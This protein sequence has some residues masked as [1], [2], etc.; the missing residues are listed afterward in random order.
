L[1][2]TGS[3]SRIVHHPLPQDDPMQRCPDITLARR[4]LDWQPEVPLDEGLA[5]T[6]TYFDNLLA[7]RG[8]RTTRALAAE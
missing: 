5:R 2:L 3:S 7:K 1:H 4:L 6:I 8:E